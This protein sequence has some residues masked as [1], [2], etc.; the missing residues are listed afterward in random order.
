MNRDDWHEAQPHDLDPDI[1]CGFDFG[2]FGTFARGAP[3]FH[4]GHFEPWRQRHRVCA[5]GTCV[6]PLRRFCDASVG[7]KYLYKTKLTGCLIN[8]VP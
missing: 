7:G 6:L 1:K 4:E 8:I 3:A 2:T 5:N